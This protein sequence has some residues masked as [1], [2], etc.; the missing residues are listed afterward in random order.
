[1]NRL[2]EMIPEPL[3]TWVTSN[4][5]R[6]KKCWGVK[7][8]SVNLIKDCD[9]G[10]QEMES[11]TGPAEIW[12]I[13]KH[14]YERVLEKIYS[15]RPKKEFTYIATNFIDNPANYGNDWASLLSEK[16]TYRRLCLDSV[17]NNHDKDTVDQK[18]HNKGNIKELSMIEE[19]QRITKISGLFCKA[20]DGSYVSLISLDQKQ[21]NPNEEKT[22]SKGVL[23]IGGFS[24][25]M[26]E[27]YLDYVPVKS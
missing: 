5:V 22:M 23:Q 14:D 10:N 11:I 16:V 2:L 15:A 9:I 13:D 12:I 26:F 27:Y 4:F 25:Y 21:L 20:S 18:F 24:R 3:V 6:P 1:M 8:E 19:G 7:N 17:V